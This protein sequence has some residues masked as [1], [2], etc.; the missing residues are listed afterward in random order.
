MAGRREPG[1]DTATQNQA[2]DGTLRVMD[3]N[4]L[5]RYLRERREAVAPESVGLPRGD[6]RRT[7]GLR[8]AE[9]ATLAGV[10]VDYLTRLEQGRDRHPS[11]QVLS[12]LADTLRLTGDERQL[13]HRL[14]SIAGAGEVCPESADPA[15]EL[16]PSVLAV[17]ERL[18]PTPAFIRNRLTD[19]TAHTEGWARLVDGIGLLEDRSPNLAR[20][21]FTHPSAREVYP[22]WERAADDMTAT[23][24]AENHPDDPHFAAFVD[25]L[26][27]I[28]GAQIAARLAAGP[29]VAPTVGT[30]RMNHPEV[31]ELRLTIESFDVADAV[32]H[33]VIHVP[34]DEVTAERL[35]RLIQR[36][37]GALRAVPG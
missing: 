3:D 25:D 5:G 37:P 28:G 14:G 1:P 15:T 30:T 2:R 32:Q 6:R 16:R 21:L 17:L 35:D 9:L 20:Y 10:S 11:P 18:E 34:Q 26:A 36:R 23:L 31:G 29:A 8:R 24:R 12:A 19:V 4:S 7:P 22:D 33:L 13:L 27:A